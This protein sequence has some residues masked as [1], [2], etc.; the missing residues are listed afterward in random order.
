[1]N[2]LKDIHSKADRRCQP[3]KI[4]NGDGAPEWATEEAFARDWTRGCDNCDAKPVVNATGMCGPCTF[5]LS[6][7][8]GGNW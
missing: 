2:A 8:L 6:E 5:G 1:M 7:T 4:P 3:S